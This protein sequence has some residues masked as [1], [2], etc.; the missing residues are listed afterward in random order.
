MG[1]M[2]KKK[3]F[4]LIELLVVIAIIALLMSILMPALAKVKRQAQGVACQSV[5]RQWSLMF[6]MYTEDSD[7]WVP[8]GYTWEYGQ[9]KLKGFW[10]VALRRY[11][12]MN[13]G[14]KIFFC[15]T[16]TKIREG[17]ETG[18]KSEFA[19]YKFAGLRNNPCSSYYKDYLS[20]QY[21]TN[22]LCV[23]GSIGYNF[24]IANSQSDLPD[25]WD[26]QRREIR[27][28]RVTGGNFIPVFGDCLIEVEP[29]DYT[30]DAPIYEGAFN[31][32]GETNSWRW[33]INRHG[34][35]KEGVTNMSFLDGTV[36]KVGLK[37]LWVLHWNKDWKQDMAD[38]PY[39]TIDWSDG[40]GWMVPFKD[41]AK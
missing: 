41:Y 5:L 36:R 27:N 1:V 38:N 7:G 35:K 26:Q 22:D 34:S 16:A 8:A 15:P 4:T 21:L 29:F 12:P 2:V 30:S 10:I 23:Q 14:F 39:S 24:H 3:A 11:Y 9:L 6:T 17:G 37:E 25:P 13:K 18:E 33:C 28:V 40:T 19:A 31:I 20:P 32:S